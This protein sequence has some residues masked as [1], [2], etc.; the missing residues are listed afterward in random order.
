M[1]KIRLF[2]RRK[3]FY[4]R[5][6]HKFCLTIADIRAQVFRVARFT[7]TALDLAFASNVLLNFFV[8]IDNLADL[9]G[10]VDNAFFPDGL[11]D[12][13]GNLDAFPNSL[14]VAFSFAYGTFL[15]LV[16]RVMTFAIFAHILI[17]LLVS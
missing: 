6:R 8:N 17:F 4:Y 13:L 10:L 15:A 1:K 3:N 7:N 14:V 5:K 2:K 9:D 16:A 12:P 11:G